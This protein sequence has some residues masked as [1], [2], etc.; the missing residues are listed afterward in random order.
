MSELGPYICLRH[1]L[2]FELTKKFYAT[3]YVSG[4]SNDPNTWILEWMI[5][6]QVFHMSSQE[7]MGIVNI[8][9]HTGEQPKIYLLPEMPD[10]EFASLLD[11]EVTADF[12]PE[13][14]R[15]KHL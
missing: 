5:Q 12:M 15:P 1:T 13:N 10:A 14:I 8:P 9:C 11:P 2:N 3:L 4:E 7:F 6:G